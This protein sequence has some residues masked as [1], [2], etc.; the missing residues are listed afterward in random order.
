MGA[1]A[2]KLSQITKGYVDLANKAKAAADKRR[3]A[4][5]KILQETQQNQPQH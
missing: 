5:E 3:E 2:Q 1:Q 4:V